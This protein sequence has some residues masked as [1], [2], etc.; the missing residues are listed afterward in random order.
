MG[1]CTDTLYSYSQSTGEFLNIWRSTACLVVLQHPTPTLW[2]LRR[3]SACRN[4]RV[5]LQRICTLQRAG[6]DWLEHICIQDVTSICSQ[7]LYTL[8][9]KDAAQV[10]CDPELMGGLESL[11]NIIQMYLD[12]DHEPSITKL[13]LHTLLR[14]CKTY[15]VLPS[16]LILEGVV[17]Q[18]TRPLAIG[19]YSEVWRGLYHNDPVA[20]KISR[21]CTQKHTPRQRRASPFISSLLFPTRLPKGVVKIQ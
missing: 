11:L 5:L 13:Y 21:V 9:S 16:G 4:L 1:S 19:R 2:K 14:L 7:L 8:R 10:L 15:D 12:R 17:L 6:G 3:D 20:V 18:G